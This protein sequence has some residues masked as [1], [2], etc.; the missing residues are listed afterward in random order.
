MKQD[1]YK[2]DNSIE[3]ILNH[4]HTLFLDTKEYKSIAS[5]L[6]KKDY[7]VYFPYKDAERVILYTNE[8]P[9]VSLFQIKSFK[10]LRHQDILG[11]ILGLNISSSYLGD[12]IIDN[13]N[14]YFYILSELSNFIKENLIFVGNNK[15]VLEELDIHTLDNYERKYEELDFIVTSIRIDNIIAKIINTNRDNV[16][17]KIKNKEV[18]LN[19]DV[20][21]KNSCF[22]KEGDIFSIRR[23]GK[24]KFVGV[25]NITKKERKVVKCLKYI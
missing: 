1:I 25:I 9:K 17:E 22:L 6:H 7:Q 23:Y 21:T 15:I 12:I 13:G 8:I 3:K 10:E 4:K 20:L 18:I 5:K 16:I 19:Y 2:I 11:S 14:Y 24:Y